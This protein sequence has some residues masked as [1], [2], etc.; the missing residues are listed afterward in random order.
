MLKSRGEGSPQSCSPSSNGRTVKLLGASRPNGG[1]AGEGDAEVDRRARSRV[2]ESMERNP[3]A[4]PKPANVRPLPQAAKS[5]SPASAPLAAP[6]PATPAG[7]RELGWLPDCVYTGE[8][9]EAGMAFFADAQGRVSR[10]SRE[11]KDLAI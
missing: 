2:V 6:K 11:P 5:P 1:H 10:F 9:F 4:R 3:S 7:P 8:K